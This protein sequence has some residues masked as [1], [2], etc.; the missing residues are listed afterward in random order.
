RRRQV[1]G[2]VLRAEEHV[3][4]GRVEGLAVVLAVGEQQIDPDRGAR[5]LERVAKRDEESDTRRAVVGAQDGAVPVAEHRVL[6][7]G[8]TPSAA[9]RCPG[10]CRRRRA[11]GARAAG[12]STSARGPSWVK[13]WVT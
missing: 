4:E 2:E 10:A 13:V 5:L 8:G 3:G 12:S 11:R 6:V 1:F 9:G 7:R